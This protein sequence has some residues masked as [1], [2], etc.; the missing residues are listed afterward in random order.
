MVAKDKENFDKDFA[1]LLE[2]IK[3]ADGF[4]LLQRYIH[5]TVHLKFQFSIINL[6]EHFSSSHGPNSCYTTKKKKT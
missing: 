1:T 6:E 3:Y 2:A 5:G 4:S